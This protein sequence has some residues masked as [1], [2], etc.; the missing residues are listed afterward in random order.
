[1]KDGICSKCGSN[2]VM[3]A[4]SIADRGNANRIQDVMS[5]VVDEEPNAIIFNRLKTFRIGAWI[6]ADCGYT[7]LYTVK[8][9][10]LKKSLNKFLS[11]AKPLKKK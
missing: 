2:D 10:E 6:C 8:P 9:Q 11:K 7:E 1:M 4:V 3:G 5:A